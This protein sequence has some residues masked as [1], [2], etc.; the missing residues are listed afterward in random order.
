MKYCDYRDVTSVY[1]LNSRKLPGHFSYGLG[2]KLPGLWN[3]KS[4]GNLCTMCLQHFLTLAL[5]LLLSPF[6]SP[7]PV[8]A[9]GSRGGRG[10][11]KKWSNLFLILLSVCL[12][13]SCST[14][15]YFSHGNLYTG[16]AQPT[17]YLYLIC[18]HN[19][20]GWRITSQCINK[21][22]VLYLQPKTDF[23]S[24]SE[25]EITLNTGSFQLGAV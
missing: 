22:W 21:M 7:F 11:K 12:S 24:S 19:N 25:V 23:P 2:T 4:A 20:I 6:L 1:S 18:T 16:L 3:L 13:H 10:G 15:M 9:I 17:I 5:S 8:T 14:V